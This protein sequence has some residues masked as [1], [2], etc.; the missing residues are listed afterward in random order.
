MKKKIYVCCGTGI[1]T[2]TVIVKKVS[3]ILSEHQ[4]PF[5]ISQGIIS[6]VKSK[7]ENVKPDLVISSSVITEELGVPVVVGSSF[8]T[9][10]NTQKT[11]DMILSILTEK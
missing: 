11:I 10:I 5:E 1:A 6:D 8:L 2:S 4:I 3:E 7:V 9:G